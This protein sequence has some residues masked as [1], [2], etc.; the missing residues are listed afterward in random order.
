MFEVFLHTDATSLEQ[1]LDPFDLCLQVLKF[2]V[3][4]LVAL[5][6]LVDVLLDLV[7]FWSAHQLTIVIDHATQ[8]VLFPDLLNLICEIFYSLPCL[9][10]VHA[11]LFASGVLIFQQSTILFHSLIFAIAFSKHIKCL[12]S[13]CQVFQAT[14]DWP[15]NQSL[16]LFKG[17]LKPSFT[18]LVTMRCCCLLVEFELHSLLLN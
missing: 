16:R 7:F 8:S 11:K 5:L 17:L 15:I 4:R 6:V 10:N 1:V 9:V 18:C 13:I 2:S 14:L 3:L 12:G